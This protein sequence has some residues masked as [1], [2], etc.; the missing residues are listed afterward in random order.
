MLMSMT[1]FG[2][3]SAST[4]THK[5]NVE[6][7]SLN[8]KQLDLNVRLPFLFR[9]GELE[10]RAIVGRAIERGK[11]DLLVTCETLPE[12]DTAAPAELNLDVMRK[13]RP[14]GR[15]APHCHDYAGGYAH[16]HS[17]GG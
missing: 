8:S 6:I 17:G 14:A 2:K 9:E 15:L 5:I 3:A 13:Y 1:G 10:A 16:F 12:A 4:R 11:A 7:K